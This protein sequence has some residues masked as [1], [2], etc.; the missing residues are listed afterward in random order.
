[1]C[2]MLRR[3]ARHRP[4][5]LVA[6]TVAGAVVVLATFLPWLHSGTTSRSSYDL[7]GVLARLDIAPHGMVSRLITWWPVVPLLVT[8]A[9]VMAWWR[10]WVPS[11]VTAL[12]AIAYAGGVG[13]SLVVATRGTGIGLG[14]GPLLC[15]V[16]SG[17]FLVTSVWMV[18]T[19]A[20][21]RAA[22]A[23]T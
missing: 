8:C 18:F 17:V 16:A 4:S 3:L 12:L 19:H 1:M 23:R 6:Y 15:A 11:M 21:E 2:P 9:V 13:T 7:L 14:V 5:S 20:S 10:W 22:R